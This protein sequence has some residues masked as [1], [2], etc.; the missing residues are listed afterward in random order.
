MWRSNSSWKA[1]EVHVTCGNISRETSPWMH[2]NSVDVMREPEAEKGHVQNR[3]RTTMCDVESRCP[4]PAEDPA[5]EVPGKLVMPR[6]HRRMR[7]ENALPAYFIQILLGR[8][9][10][11]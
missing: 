4:V 1:G 8:C 3:I 6:G 9:T 7:R 2:R 10:Q 5:H 11:I